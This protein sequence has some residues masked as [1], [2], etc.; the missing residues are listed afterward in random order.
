MLE[1]VFYNKSKNIS[2]FTKRSG[3]DEEQSDGDK[4]PRPIDSKRLFSDDLSSLR[5]YA[6]VHMMIHSDVGERF[7]RTNDNDVYL[8]WR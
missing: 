4:W 6:Y 1:V 7:K 5:L 8:V 3:M 2:D